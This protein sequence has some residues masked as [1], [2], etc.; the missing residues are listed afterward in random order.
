[1]ASKAHNAKAFVAHALP[2]SEGAAQGTCAGVEA[3]HNALDA[4]N[5]WTSGFQTH[6]FLKDGWT[7]RMDFSVAPIAAAVV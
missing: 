1:M 2:S 5:D 6:R 7:A 4:T 3:P